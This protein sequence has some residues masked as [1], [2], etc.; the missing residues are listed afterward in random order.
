MFHDLLEAAQ[1]NAL[2]ASFETIQRRGWEA[3]P[4]GKL[5]ESQITPTCA[6]KFPELTFER[7]RHAGSLAGGSFRMWNICRLC[8]LQSQRFLKP[9]AP[10][11]IRLQN[12][13]S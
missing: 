11:S 3:Q 5:R 1:S 9:S 12:R 7:G 6:E 13:L 4:L 10:R 2:F 8:A